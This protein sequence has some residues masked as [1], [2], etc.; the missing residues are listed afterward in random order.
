MNMRKSIIEYAIAHYD[1]PKWKRIMFALAY[2]A[3][4]R[5]VLTGKYRS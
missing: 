4:L 5:F 3:S 2:G 1:E